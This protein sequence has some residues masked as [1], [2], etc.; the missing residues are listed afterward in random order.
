MRARQALLPLVGLLLAAAALFWM[1]DRR[2]HTPVDGLPRPGQ[3]AKSPET[4]YTDM[5]KP[6]GGPVWFHNVAAESGIDFRH[7]SG[8]SA[9][10]PFP[11]ANGSGVAAFDYDLDG[12]YDLYFATG[13]PF[14]IDPSRQGPVNRVY[15]NGGGWRFADQTATTGLGHNG[16]SAGLSVGDYDSDG[17]PDVF[18]AC[19]GPNVLFRNRGDGTFQQVGQVAGVDGPRWATGAAFL[20]YDADGHLDLYVGNYAKWSWEANPYCGDRSRGVRL[21]CSPGSVEPEADILYRNAGDGTFEDRTTASGVAVR[22][23]RAQGVIAADINRDGL[24]DLY[25]SND[26]HP[27]SL[28]VNEGGG[29]FQDVSEASGT[30]YDR[31]G[32]AQAGMGVDVA[33][34]NGDGLP[35]IFVTN[36]EDEYNT[37]YENFGA[38]VFQ[39][40]TQTSGLAAE[41][42]PWV[43]WGTRLADSDLDGWP[44]VVVTNGHVDDNR[45]LLGQDSP[46]RQPPL[47]WRNTGGR[48]T[49][50]GAAAGPYFSDRH[51]G[52][53]LTTADLDDDG[54]LDVVIGH[55]DAAPALLRNERLASRLRGRD[56]VRLRLVGRRGNRDA[57]GSTLTIRC[58][59]R[60]IVQQVVGGGS[61]LSASDL[62]QVFAIL[63]HESEAECEIAWPGGD[64]SSVVSLSPGNAY[65]V[66][67]P[68]EPSTPCV[69]LLE[70]RH[71]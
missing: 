36:F 11:A 62:R 32:R 38:G 33:D 44:D 13:T 3:S 35:E 67:E 58:A 10:K 23:A 19:Y 20:D 14:P 22:V 56:V 59:G 70:P 49:F 28:F 66:I 55:Q 68:S 45:H 57:V 69:L 9:E 43:G 48:F 17:F 52:R 18:V 40:V 5:D 41:S 7:E 29:T 46:Y 31:L 16:Y 63:P 51:V 50:L 2:G 4:D 21:Y 30:A 60:T 27:N 26:V 65:V 64:H 6:P 12:R 25:V 47:A 71:D 24:I 42:L 15:R 61:Y 34:T 53:A 39:D 8:T 37:L 1:R 54:D